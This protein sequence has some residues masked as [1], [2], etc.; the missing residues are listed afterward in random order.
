[1]NTT[2]II[3]CTELLRGHLSCHLNRRRVFFFYDHL[4]VPKPKPLHQLSDLLH[5]DLVL[6]LLSLQQPTLW[7]AH[8]LRS[9]TFFDLV[10]FKK[11]AACLTI[12]CFAAAS[13]SA[14]FLCT[15][16]RVKHC[17]VLKLLG[18]LLTT[19]Q[20]RVDWRYR[21]Q[22]FQ[23]FKAVERLSTASTCVASRVSK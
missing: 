8:I 15:L 16:K 3:I 20:W 6:W 17:K 19:I 23:T 5:K 7:R 9:K 13:W 22:P 4:F 10:L 12:T 14:W 1:M 2:L 11:I 21:F 18:H